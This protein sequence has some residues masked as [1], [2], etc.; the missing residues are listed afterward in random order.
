MGLALR[1][2]AELDPER[3]PSVLERS[4]AALREAVAIRERHGLAEGHA[5][6]LFHLGVTLAESNPSEARHCFE[7]AAKEFDR[8]DKHDSATVARSR[9]AA[10]KAGLPPRSQ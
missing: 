6:S 3:A 1:R 7:R 9:L 5:L 2:L 4:A 10:S 8:L